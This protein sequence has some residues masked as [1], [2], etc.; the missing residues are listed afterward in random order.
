[1]PA[2]A[3]FHVIIAAH[4][5]I[6]HVIK[7]LGLAGA[8]NHLL[9]L[10][11]GLRSEGLDARL[12]LWATPD[13]P[14]EDICAAAQAQGIPLERWLMPRH[15]DPLFF[16]RVVKHLR[17]TRPALVHTHLV[18]AETYAIPAARLARV[19]YVV[20]SSHNDDPF[21]RHPLFRAR[22]RLLWDMTDK[23]IAISQALA[24]FLYDVEG[25]RAGQIQ[26]IHYGLPP[27][28]RTATGQLRAKLALPSS[29]R[30][31]GSACR[32]VP[33]K[34]LNFALA[35]FA[36][37]APSYPTLHYALI[38]DGPL[39][40]DLEAQAQTL[41]LGDR[42]HFLGWQSEVLPLL[43]DLEVF[44]APSLWE[45]FGLVLLEAMSQARPIVASRVSAIPEIVVEGK[46]G[47]LVPP[48][49]AKALAGALRRLLDN[50]AEAE[51]MGANGR[52]RLENHFSP[53]KMLAETLALYR[54]LGLA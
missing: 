7:G 27:Y 41:G 53:Q 22:S 35:A 4:M 31:I 26:V 6:L 25:A 3:G 34:G 44:L 13:R 28:P 45:G 16:A 54:G 1:M 47:L 30:L 23:G 19:P 36:Q 39:R 8:E 12:W 10:L 40:G 24:S 17:Q 15:L 2:R 37:L 43:A 14:A 42:V 33:Q 46:T 48:R 32:L 38:G 11:A 51:A 21:R 50:P 52:K 5:H 18:H 49:E 9:T 20:N 29:A